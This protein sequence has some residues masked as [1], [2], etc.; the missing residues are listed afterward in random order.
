MG[1]ANSVHS[2]ALMGRR[3]TSYAALDST[4]NPHPEWRIR[5]VASAQSSA[6]TP[7]G[8]RASNGNDHPPIFSTHR[9]EL[10]FTAETIAYFAGERDEPGTD[11]IKR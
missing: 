3:G 8:N 5:S 6:C 11:G 2:A 4:E 1:S 9:R 7:G 10:C